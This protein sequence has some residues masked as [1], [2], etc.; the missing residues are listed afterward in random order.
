MGVA[1][2]LDIN[3]AWTDALS[4]LQ[5]N[6]GVVTIVAG[7]FFFLPYLAV[8]LLMPEM[9]SGMTFDPNEQ[10]PSAAFDQMIAAYSEIW[11]VIALVTIVQVIGTLALLAMLRSDDRPTV[12][13]A[14]GTGAKG[15]LPYIAAT[16]I[17]YL[18]V[19]IVAGVVLGL[20][21]ASQVTALAVIVGLLT[22]VAMI[23]VAVKISLITP[24][25]AIDK[26][27]NPLRA[28]A[29]SWQMTKGNSLRLLAFYAL[30]VLA[31][32]VVSIVISLFVVLV[33]GLMGDEIALIGS[34]IFNAAI[35]AVYVVL[36]LGVLA[37]V[38]RQ[39][40]GR[41]HVPADNDADEMPGG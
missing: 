5:A 30:L 28:V 36:M 9:A 33:F 38:H 19:A 17:V 11:W 29:R 31:I 18:G 39:L 6:I 10:D 23:Y 32:G 4:L 15:L 34:A 13:E 27:Y 41:A 26:V 16:L 20:A 40:A 35:N 8:I 37:A 2:K 21:I 12:G 7:V 3:R 24:V 14:I 22:I 25:I 1:M